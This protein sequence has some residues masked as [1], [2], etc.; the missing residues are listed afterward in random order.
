MTSRNVYNRIKKRIKSKRSHHKA[1]EAID[2]V[3]TEA[4]KYG[5]Q[6]CETWH[7]DYW[8]F[9]VHTSKM[10]KNFWRHLIERRKN[11]LDTTVICTTAKEEGIEIYNTSTLEALKIMKQLQIDLNT[12]YCDHKT[13]QDEYLLRKANLAQDAREEDKANAIKTI[14]KAECRNQ[15]YW[16]FRSHQGTGISA[17]AVN[18][19]Q[20]PKSWKTMQEYEEVA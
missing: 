12:H 1:A 15:C 2:T 16:D 18:Q 19:I 8:D 17:Q 14:K 3:I 10:K 5:E 7:K 20:I 9:D 13:K 11:H 4:T 6:Q